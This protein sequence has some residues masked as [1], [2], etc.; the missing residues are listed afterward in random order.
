MYSKYTCYAF[1]LQALT[2]SVLCASNGTAQK[3][4]SVKEVTLSIHFED[5][6]VVEAF[7]KLEAVTDY[8]FSFN[9]SDL[10]DVKAVNG[11]YQAQSLY[12]ILIDISR[13][14]SIGFK[15]VNHLI[16]ARKI[17][18]K[19]AVVP[20][21]EIISAI[22]VSGTVIALSD[23]EPLPGVNIV[24]K[25]KG[26]G[27]VTDIDG[28]YSINVPNEDDIL[29]FSSI[30]Y[31]TEEVPVNGRS[32]INMSLA[33]DIQ[34]LS[35]IVVVGYGTQE[36]RDLTGSVAS[37]SAQ[38]IK[39]VPIPGFDQALMGKAAGV[40]VSQV[41]ADPG[42]GLT[43]RVRGIN[44]VNAGVNPLYVVDGF[45]LPDD[46]SR[47]N[48]PLNVINPNDIESIE[49]LKDA[50][51]AAIY[52]SRASNGVVIITTKSGKSGAPKIEV[53]ASYGWQR[54]IRKMDVMNTA[55]Y[56]EYLFD[57]TNNGWL[58]EGPE[59]AAI[60]D[61]Y[62]VREAFAGAGDQKWRYIPHPFLVGD[63]WNAAPIIN[64]RLDTVPDVDWQDAITRV[65][66]KQNYNL[67][68]SGGSDKVTYLLSGNYF[69]QQ[70]IVYK[71]ALERFAGRLKLD[72][73]VTDRLTV[74][75]N[76]APS[77]IVN[78]NAQ[79]SNTLQGG[80]VFLA[81]A[82][83]H[84]FREVYD[85]NG[86]YAWPDD[87]YG[88]RQQA[89]I[90][91][92]IREPTRENTGL[93][94]ISAAYGE[95]K[96]LEGLSF[97]SQISASIDNN[98]YREFTPS[99]SSDFN[100]APGRENPNAQFNETRNIN[101][102][103]QNYLNYQKSFNEVHNL[104]ATVG[105]T[106]QKN[107]RIRTA[108]GARS[109]DN[110]F[111]PTVASAT[112]ILP[113]DVE[114]DISEWSFIGQ[115]ARATYD[116]NGKYYLTAS[117]RRDGSS[118]F[119]SENRWGVFPSVAA[120]WRVSDEPFMQNV[121][122]I[123]NLKFRASYGQLGNSSIGNYDY[124]GRLTSDGA[125]YTLGGSFVN[126]FRQNS[127]QN[128]DLG[129][130]TTEEVNLG[131]DLGLLK[132]RVTATVDAYQRNTNDMLL[133]VPVPSIIGFGDSRLNIGKVRN[134]GLEVGIFSR[135]MVGTFQWTTNANITFERNKVLNLG[136]EGNSITGDRGIFRTEAGRPIASFWSEPIDGVYL[137]EEEIAGTP[138]YV[139]RRPPAPGDW[140][141]V[142]VNGDGKVNGNDQT[143]L[144]SP[145]PNFYYGLT[146]TFSYKNFDLN[147][148]VQGV[149][150]NKVYNE[151]QRYLASMRA[152]Y[153]GHRV[154][155]DRYRNPANPGDGITPRV[156]T[157]EGNRTTG[158]GRTTWHIEDGSY[159][160]VRNVT[161]GYSL[162]TGWLERVKMR[163]ARLYVTVE[164][165]L[166]VSDYRGYNPE[167]NFRGAESTVIGF[168]HGGY[169]L[170]RTISI[171]ANIGF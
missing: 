131:L 156:N 132:N 56:A 151:T 135:N 25:G 126:G 6:N 130:E 53:S 24:V 94:L 138:L 3:V 63:D 159:I 47:Q 9:K 107:N 66:P 57:A 67:S 114:Q 170:A 15:Q 103:S 148:D 129:W 121:E 87:F 70:G 74:G 34:S 171:G 119:G 35:E 105:Y 30:G 109:F 78:Q 165:A 146:N 48:N 154:L 33:E 59:G 77:Y 17:I 168:D 4:K 125:G 104:G 149:Q 150:G 137:S 158:Y 28:N 139:G 80:G 92:E 68:V 143:F 112:E 167:A 42:G 13:Q 73:N 136:F 72:V 155:L 140:Q 22:A 115:F 169:P 61:P 1:L 29:V 40:R 75:M 99:S 152:D 81:A 134:R 58:T 120:A 162:P 96:I 65:A 89:N 16:G 26:I 93:R 111:V 98:Q 110:E 100:V 122:F 46:F 14:T 36:K 27:T 62:S 76:L 164:N 43:V 54:M 51:A 118:R 161:L 153:N 144:G 123:S 21:V 82:S 37:V 141:W 52:G 127:L 55:E 7:R 91:A 44:S 31:T 12:N 64:P 20:E 32:A 86:N 71:S 50:S 18:K 8:T 10:K 85:E 23:E 41:S 97:R 19:N 117:V 38:Q 128:P 45:P 106:V 101:W 102:E 69:N 79:F 157:R 5:E 49:V 84:P 60:T 166:F 83:M 90:V 133:N 124:L 116:Y 39:D 108:I 88:L 95:Y 113:D 2:L 160:A 145:L 11:D 147:I 163:T 142:D